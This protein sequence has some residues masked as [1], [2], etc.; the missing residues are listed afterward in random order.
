MDRASKLTVPAQKRMD[1]AEPDDLIEV[2]VELEASRVRSVGTRSDQMANLE[3]AFGTRSAAVETAIREAGGEV[4][5]RVALVDSLR[6][7][8][9]ARAVPSLAQIDSVTSI[10]VPRAIT[11]ER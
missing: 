11:R 4:L 7:R 5:Q 1:G 3:R 6:V 9:P 10:D 2:V 8:L